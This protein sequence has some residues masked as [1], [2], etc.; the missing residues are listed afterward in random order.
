MLKYR[1]MGKK[2][3]RLFEQFMPEN[4]RLH[5]KPD[6]DH[7]TFTGTV[8]ITGKKVGR[9]SQR[10]TF[11]QKGLTVTSATIIKHD[12]TG[13]QNLTVVRINTHDSFNEIRVH[14]SDKVF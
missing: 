6:R 4:Y 7:M 10:L 8:S 2:V 14:T 5:L 9:P 3:A 13:D 12:K 11:H 1:D